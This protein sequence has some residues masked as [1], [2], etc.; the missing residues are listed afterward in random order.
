MTVNPKRFRLFFGIFFFTVLM[1]TGAAASA[2][3]ATYYIDWGQGNDQNSGTSK[4]SPWKRH[5]YMNGWSGSYSHSPGDVFIFRGGVTWPNSCFALLISSGGSS[6]APDRYDVDKS[7][8]QGSSWSRP[9]FDLQNQGMPRDS[10]P[11]RITNVSNVV[12]RSIEVRNQKI[13]S[14]QEYSRGGISVE[15]SSGILIE[16]CY[17]HDWDVSGTSVDST[18][19]GVTSASSSGVIVRQLRVHG[20]QLSGG[21][22]SGCGLD[23]DYQEISGCDISNVSTGLKVSGTV[24]GCTIYNVLDSFDSARHENGAWLNP[25]T[26]FF[27]NVMHDVTVG[28]AVYPIPGWGGRSGTIEVYNNVV[29]NTGPIPIQ[30]DPSGSVASSFTTVRV[31]NNSLQHGSA[32][33]RVVPRSYPVSVLDIRNNLLVSDTSE[34]ICVGGSCGGADSLTER[35]NVSL[36]S[37]KA[38]TQ[39][40]AT[41][42]LLEPNANAVS[43]V[44]AG[45]PLA[46]T[47]R[48]DFRGIL[49]PQ[50]NG[51][52]VGAFEW[53][54]TAVT[55][56]PPR[57]LRVGD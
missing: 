29:Y 11:I 26:V 46:S 33:I 19:G 15:G 42:S 27:N 25:G 12:V 37:S 13:I 56:A 2:F 1:V 8:Y 47:Y 32:C 17:L 40:L 35:S 36:S 41:S 55:I 21:K 48:H 31:F 23:G 43:V 18:F 53:T 20:P 16:D 34:T 7:W 5:P 4:S 38:A 3:G 28:T 30:V 57:N 44:D 24:E 45:E 10:R 14:G 22:S 54:G 6:S 50:G 49:R 52:D 51:W 9:V 39:G